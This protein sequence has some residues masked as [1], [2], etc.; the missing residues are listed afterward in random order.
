MTK[1][2]VPFVVRQTVSVVGERLDADPGF[3]AFSAKA[4]YASAGGLDEFLAALV[5][6]RRA[7]DGFAGWCEDVDACR[8]LVGCVVAVKR[9]VASAAVAGRGVTEATFLSRLGFLSG[10]VLMREVEVALD[11]AMAVHPDETSRLTAFALCAPQKT[12][13]AQKEPASSL[14]A[15]HAAGQGLRGVRCLS[16]LQSLTRAPALGPSEHD[17][18]WPSPL[19]CAT[20]PRSRRA[21]QLY[22][23][24]EAADSASSDT[25]LSDTSTP[26]APTLSPVHSPTSAMS[27]PRL[28]TPIHQ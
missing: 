9:G 22:I 24:G 16:L 4:Y 12:Q 7:A 17:G 11:G 5:L 2:Q 10:D 18:E 19:Q 28:V 13:R 23:L 20:T 15:P 8:L 14:S 3:E 6:L 1:S 21:R 27:S 26:A 25:A